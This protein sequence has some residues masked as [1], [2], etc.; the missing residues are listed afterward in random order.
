MKLQNDAR[1]AL[2]ICLFRIGI[3]Q[4]R[5]HRAIDAGS[6]FDHVRIETLLRLLVEVRK[7]FSRIRIQALAFCVFRF[8]RM[9][10]QIE[11]GAIRD[12]HQFVPLALVFFTLREK[13]ILNIHGALGVM[14][15]LFFRL[16]VKTQ[17]RAGDANALKPLIAGVNPFLMQ[18]LR[19]RRV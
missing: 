6:R 1:L 2:V 18:Q 19:L 9:R 15:Q 12:T 16:F 17:V 8:F 4:E 3:H 13:A 11:I 14:S 5:E 7:V 10:P